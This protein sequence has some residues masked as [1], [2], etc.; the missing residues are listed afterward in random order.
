LILTEMSS[1]RLMSSGN[2]I[3]E[4]ALINRSLMVGVGRNADQNATCN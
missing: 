1:P 4:E 3:R 2:G